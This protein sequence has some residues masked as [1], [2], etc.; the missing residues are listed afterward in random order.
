MGDLD[1]HPVR[2]RDRVA[3]LVVDTTRLSGLHGRHNDG[4]DAL[5]DVHFEFDQSGLRLLFRGRFDDSS[6]LDADIRAGGRADEGDTA[7]DRFDN[8]IRLLCGRDRVVEKFLGR[9][10]N[11]S[12]VAVVARRQRGQRDERETEVCSSLEFHGIAP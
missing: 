7:R 1:I 9:L 2:N 11:P 12:D 10:L 5:G 6:P 8:Q 4:V 3:H